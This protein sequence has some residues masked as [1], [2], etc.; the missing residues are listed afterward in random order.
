MP[1]FFFPV[2]NLPQADGWVKRLLAFAWRT[3]RAGTRADSSKK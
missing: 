3:I 1:I 2:V